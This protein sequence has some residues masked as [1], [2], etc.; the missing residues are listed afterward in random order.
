MARLTAS[1][2]LDT[3]ATGHQGFNTAGYVKT[4]AVAGGDEALFNSVAVVP[5]GP[6]DA[7]VIMVGGGSQ[8]DSN[9]SQL[10]LAAFKP[11][12]APYFAFNA[13]GG[14]QSALGATATGIA[15]V[16]TGSAAGNVVAVGPGS[17]GPP[18]LLQFQP[19]GTPF[20][21]FTSVGAQSGEVV[22]QPPREPPFN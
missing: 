6:S 15:I 14:L 22:V 11:G 10:T 9:P 19:N 1:G 7:G 12:G 13:S 16:T 5:P 18:V 20:T 17:S 21:P 8:I 4:F 3:T 2:A